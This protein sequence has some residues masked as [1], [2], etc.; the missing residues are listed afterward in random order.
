MW[1]AV[2][3]VEGEELAKELKDKLIKEG[4]LIK[5]KPFS[6]E[7]DTIIYKIMAPEFEANEVHSAI[8][9]LRY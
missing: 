6:K 8:I 2:H 7:G 1:T 3:I 9:D 5:I 4:F